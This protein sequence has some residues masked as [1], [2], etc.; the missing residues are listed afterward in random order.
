MTPRVLPQYFK[1][2]TMNLLSSTSLLLIAII[3]TPFTSASDRPKK[4]QITIIHAGTLLA[5]PGKPA[6]DQQSL[7]IK[8]GKIMSVVDGFVQADTYQNK[9]NVT[10]KDLSDKFVMPGM[11]DMHVHLTMGNNAGHE[12]FYTTSD[13]DFAMIAVENADKTLMAGITTVR[14][15]AALSGEA[16]IA[17]RDAINRKVVPGP[18]I[19][20]AGK[21]LSATAG[22]ADHYGVREDFAKLYK[23]TGVCDG[24]DDCRRAVRDQ[25]KLGADMI[26]VMATG[27][28][29]DKNG[30]KYSPAEMF[31]D[32]FVAIVE[33]AHRLNL[34]VTAHAHGTDGINAALTAGV[35]SIEHSSYMDN[36]T[37]K[38]YKETG[39]HLVPTASLSKFFQETPTIPEYVKRSL[40]GKAKEV[41]VLLRK[42]HKKGVTISM[43]SDA[44]ISKHGRNAEELVAYVDIGMTPMEAIQAATI[45]TAALIGMSEQLGTLEPGKNADII[46]MDTSPLANIKAV[47]KVSF[48][49]RDGITYKHQ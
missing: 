29:A 27:G 11:M 15:L 44:G 13:P 21:A 5:V 36:K 33:T 17:V 42:A 41:D 38:L 10:I 28:G 2:G 4:E 49:M 39:A 43:G 12:D 23:S 45:N 20:A 18:R 24:A 9:G 19:I 3:F 22:H 40:R 6:I 35:D 31:D 32:E 34:K 46:A 16:I 7:V 48:V 47:T 30:K 25:Y 14:D 26:K 37:I 8:N 1:G